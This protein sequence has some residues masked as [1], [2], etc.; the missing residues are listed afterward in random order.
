MCVCVCVHFYSAGTDLVPHRLVDAQLVIQYG[1]GLRG[2][3][4]AV[5]EE[6]DVASLPLEV[7]KVDQRGVE[8]DRGA[9]LVD[10][11]RVRGQD[12]VEQRH[13]RAGDGCSVSSVQH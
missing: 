1:E 5:E 7:G 9:A 13:W 2:R 11:T 3:L 8:S 6:A 4:V 12:T 10:L